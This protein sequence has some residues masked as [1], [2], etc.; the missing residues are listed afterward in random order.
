MSFDQ[1]YAT[2]FHHELILLV[3]QA[4]AVADLRRATQM[5][6]RLYPEIDRIS[7]VRA[8]LRLDVPAPSAAAL[9]AC[10]AGLAFREQQARRPRWLH[11]TRAATARR[12]ERIMRYAAPLLAEFKGTDLWQQYLAVETKLHGAIARP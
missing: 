11:W 1:D 8:G 10:A 3:Q 12:H 7:A 6:G 9:Y 5:L 4:L 2:D